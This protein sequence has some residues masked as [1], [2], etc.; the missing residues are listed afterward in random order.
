MGTGAGDGGH[1]PRSRRKWA[2]LSLHQ[3]EDPREL[4]LSLHSM[5]H[6]RKALILCES[7]PPSEVSM[8]A[9]FI[10]HQESSFHT[11]LSW[12]NH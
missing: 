3:L 10:C 5:R 2:P 8:A 12:Y 11:V 6:K 1:S 4:L 7:H 9:T